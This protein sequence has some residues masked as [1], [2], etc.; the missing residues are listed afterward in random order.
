MSFHEWGDESFDWEGLDNAI[1]LVYDFC[2]KYGRFSGQVKEKY[3]NFRGYFHFGLSLHSLIFPKYFVYKHP[4]FPD[5]LWK[6]DL[7][8]ITPVLNKL[9]GKPWRLWQHFIYRTAYARALAKFPHLK[10]EIFED[11]DYPELLKGLYDYSQRRI[12]NE[13]SGKDT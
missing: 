9:S 4:K 6:A 8:Y 3:G 5:W 1:D 10:D 11:A 2:W 7:R 12:G 13:S